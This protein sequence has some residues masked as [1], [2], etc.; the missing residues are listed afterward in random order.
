MILFKKINVLVRHRNTTRRRRSDRQAQIS[1]SEDFDSA[2]ASPTDT[3]SNV[4]E[5]NKD[6]KNETDS[7]IEDTNIECPWKKQAFNFISEFTK[8]VPS[9]KSDKIFNPDT[10]AVI[11]SKENNRPTPHIRFT[12]L[13]IIKQPLSLEKVRKR[14]ESGK[15]A[16]NVELKRDFLLMLLNASMFNMHVESEVGF[17]IF[18]TK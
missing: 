15:I 2:P 12:Y 6:A 5:S 1:K 9:K 10:C 18:L 13:D 3:A 4:S 17:G 7:D 11:Y 16:N 8:R 14:I